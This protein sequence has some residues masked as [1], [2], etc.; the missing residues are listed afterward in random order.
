MT[1]GPP[2]QP[3]NV[4]AAITPKDAEAIDQSVKLTWDLPAETAAPKGDKPEFLLEMK[5]V[6]STRWT[7][8]PTNFK[9]TDTEFTLP[10]GDLKE[11][12]D[13]EFRV[14]AKNKAGLSKP[15]EPSN[16]VQTGKQ[17]T[18]IHAQRY[19]AKDSSIQRDY[20]FQVLP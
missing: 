11:Y 15:S 12:V 8:V 10:A 14:T 9:I 19:F 13:Y 17:S 18:Y 1:L 3:T 5:R 16:P 6:D 4:K 7:E 20:P 2:H